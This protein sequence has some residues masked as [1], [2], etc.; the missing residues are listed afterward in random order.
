VLAVARELEEVDRVGRHEHA[1]LTRG[2]LE[3]RR[4]GRAA[5]LGV[6]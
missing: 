4:V 6:A 3:D 5:Q 2:K 1:L